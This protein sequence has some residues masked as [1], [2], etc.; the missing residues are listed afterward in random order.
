MSRDTALA[1]RSLPVD[2]RADVRLPSL[3]K[4]HA[5][6]VAEA[7]GES[8]STLIVEALAAIVARELPKIES[9][10]LTAPE[11]AELLR[12]LAA[13]PVVTPAQRRAQKRAVELFGRS[14]LR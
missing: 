8:L 14:A 13:P 9:W 3:L 5:A 6:R 7:K 10:Q 1:Y 12:V 4:A 2:D 11:Q